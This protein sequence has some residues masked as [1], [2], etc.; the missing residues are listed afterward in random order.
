VKSRENFVA[1]VSASL[2]S[3][4]LIVGGM[5]QPAKV[6]NFL[7]VSGDWDPSLAFVMGG[8][9]LVYMPMFW[10]LAKR[11]NAPLFAKTFALPTRKDIDAPLLFGSALFGAGWGLGGFCP[12]PGLASAAAGTKPIT[13]VGAMLVG[14]L[15]VR[16]LRD[17]A[18]GRAPK[19]LQRPNPTS[20]ETT[21]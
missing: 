15:L 4:G 10:L 20:M 13:F 18:R 2:F 19:D 17:G 16:L 1:F 14:M 9:I 11:R 7:D 8:A 3:I 6:I 12:G 21:Q 5:T